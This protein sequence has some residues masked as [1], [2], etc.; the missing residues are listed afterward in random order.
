MDSEIDGIG[1]FAYKG[2]WE[3]VADKGYQVATD[4]LRVNHL[5]KKPRSGDLTRD[6]NAFNKT[7]ESDRIIAEN[8]LAVYANCG[9]CCRSSTDEMEKSTVLCSECALD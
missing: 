2:T 8:F 6:Q 9:L 7:D 3:I 4:F 1:C 5:C